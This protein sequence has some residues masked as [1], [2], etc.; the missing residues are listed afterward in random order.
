VITSEDSRFFEHHGVD[1]Q[2]VGNALKQAYRS[3]LRGWRVIA[4]ASCAIHD[5]D[6]IRRAW[7]KAMRRF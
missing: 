3:N 7:D 4:A 1:T 2:E 6:W 5:R